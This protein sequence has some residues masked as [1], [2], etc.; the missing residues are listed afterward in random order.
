[1]WGDVRT[2]QLDDWT[3]ILSVTTSETWLKMSS[4]L[5]DIQKN[6]NYVHHDLS[7]LTLRDKKYT[8][9]KE[10]GFELIKI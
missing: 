3:V 7:F 2:G 5:K 9:F 6:P 4:G 10:F 1:M 8:H